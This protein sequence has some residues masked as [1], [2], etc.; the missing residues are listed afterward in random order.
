MA[1]KRVFKLCDLDNDGILNDLELNEFQTFCFGS[2]LLSQ[3]FDD[4]KYI[5][6]SIIPDGVFDNGITLS[7]FM[8]LLKFFIQRGR[9]ELIWIV[10][11]KFG[12]NNT[13]TFD[14]Q[15]LYPSIPVP[16][17]SSVEL[18]PKGY[19][20]FTNLFKNFDKDNDGA[21]SPSE[22][23]ML[24]SICEAPPKWFEADYSQIVQTNEKGWITLEG[25]LSIWTYVSTI[26]I[27]FYLK[28]IFILD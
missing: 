10:L 22:L 11:R 27:V 12:Y 28:L 8:F 20:F 6:K 7:G 4:V 24:F 21:L 1:L 15:Y 26:E 17:G 14:N 5:L 16:Q 13:V 3:T 2:F 23:N 9:H 19:S 25:F 18:S